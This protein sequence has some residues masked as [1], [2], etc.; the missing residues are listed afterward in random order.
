MQEEIF[1]TN[2]T[3]P[4]F[5]RFLLRTCNPDQARV[6][7]IWCRDK[8]IQCIVLSYL[9]HLERDLKYNQMTRR[10]QRQGIVVYI[11]NIYPP[12]ATVFKMTTPVKLHRLFLYAYSRCLLT[13]ADDSELRNLTRLVRQEQENHKPGYVILTRI[14]GHTWSVIADGFMDEYGNQEEFYVNFR[15]NMLPQLE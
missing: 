5:H 2:P 12:I 6:A 13:H 9:P 3:L 11:N 1:Y 7:V 15:A 14:F 4:K 10:F 8:N